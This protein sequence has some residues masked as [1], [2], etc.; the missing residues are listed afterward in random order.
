LSV[1]SDK[2]TEVT[3]KLCAQKTTLVSL[4]LWNLKNVLIGSVEVA[5]A[6]SELPLLRHLNFRELRGM[7]D[8]IAKTLLESPFLLS[9]SLDCCTKL[10]D[11]TLIA[12][13]RHKTLTSFVGACCPFTDAGMLEVAQSQ[14]LRSLNLGYHKDM[15]DVSAFALAKMPLHELLLEEVLITD[16]GLEALMTSPTLK[17]LGIRDCEYISQEAIQK[18]SSHPTIKLITK[19]LN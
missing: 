16:E 1:S 8:E 10:T 7:T 5:R 17:K 3:T 4:N 11:Q 19:W 9:L 6:F 12:V 18:F 14:S 13:G 15:T 2:I